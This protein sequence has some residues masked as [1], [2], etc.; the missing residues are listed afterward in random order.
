MRYDSGD[1]H[2][3]HANALKPVKKYSGK[4]YI[5][6]SADTKKKNYLIKCKQFIEGSDIYTRTQASTFYKRG[7]VPYM[8]LL[9]QCKR[10]TIK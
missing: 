6:L 4:K 8:A 2:N 9:I 7:T 1:C 3:L 10:E 5:Y